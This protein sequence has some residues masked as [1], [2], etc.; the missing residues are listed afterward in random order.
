MSTCGPRRRGQA[1]IELQDVAD[2]L[3][4]L[5]PGAVIASYETCR[6]GS[7]LGVRELHDVP[8]DDATGASIA[9]SERQR[10]PNER[11]FPIR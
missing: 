2:V 9:E 11:C 1:T 7:G 4:D 10:R 8:P 3:A 6:L 5:V